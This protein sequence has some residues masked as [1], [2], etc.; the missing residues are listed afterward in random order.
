MAKAAL[1]HVVSLRRSGADSAPATMAEAEQVFIFSPAPGFQRF[2]FS[3]TFS[4]PLLCRRLRLY[5]VANRSALELLPSVL[6]GWM[7]IVDLF[8]RRSRQLPLSTI[9]IQL[10]GTQRTA[11]T[12]ETSKMSLGWIPFHRAVSE[13]HCR[14]QQRPALRSSRTYAHN[15]PVVFL[16][17]GSSTWTG[18]SSAWVCRQS[19]H[20][21]FQ[22]GSN[23]QHAPPSRQR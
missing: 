19:W 6:T 3:L 5:G 2:R 23:R 11:G 21:L 14:C 10:I 16:L 12:A 22:R 9:A 7:H 1:D 8:S 17:P 18:V 13:P 15:R 20:D 4:K